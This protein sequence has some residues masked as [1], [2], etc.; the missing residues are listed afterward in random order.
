MLDETEFI[1]GGAKIEKNIN[2]EFKKTFNTQVCDCGKFKPSISKCSIN[3]CDNCVFAVAPFSGAT[4]TYC[5][6]QKKKN[7]HF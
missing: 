4:V 2:P 6:M 1:K 3:I 7:R 5:K